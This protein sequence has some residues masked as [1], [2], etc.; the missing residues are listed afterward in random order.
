MTSR[1]S[2]Q[3]VTK[4]DPGAELLGHQ[5]GESTYSPSGPAPSIMNEDTIITHSSQ[6][7]KVGLIRLPSVTKPKA[8]R[9]DPSLCTQQT[10]TLAAAKVQQ[11]A[12]G[13]SHVSQETREGY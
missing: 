2:Y 11:E 8:A 4:W 7:K 5:R 1:S 13:C 9:T 10:Y 6:R 3:I 12:G